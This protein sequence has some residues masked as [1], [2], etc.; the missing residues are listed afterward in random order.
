[1][2]RAVLIVSTGA[3]V[4]VAT[5]WTSYEMAR[6]ATENDFFRAGLVRCV[7]VPKEEARLERDE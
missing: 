3:A 4:W 2:T 1:M 6:L 7:A 5:T